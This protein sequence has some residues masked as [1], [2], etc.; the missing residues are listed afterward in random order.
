MCGF[1]AFFAPG[2]RFAPAL[3]DGVEQDLLHRGPDS[4]G[5]HDEEGWALVFRRL[6]IIDSR[7]VADQP[8]VDNETGSVLVFNGE[9]YNHAALRKEL[10]QLGHRFQTD[11]DTE[12]LLIGYRQW[13]R[14][15]LDRLEGM[16]AFVIVDRA[17]GLALAARDPFGIKP[18]YFVRTPECVAFASEMRP[19]QR[20][21]DAQADADTVLELLVFGFAGGTNSNLAGIERISGGTFLEVPLAGG[22]LRRGRFFDPL[23]ALE[24]RPSIAP[25][26]AVSRAHESIE[27]SVSDHL[28]SDVGYTIELS[29]GVDSSLVAA[30]AA[31]HSNKGLKSFGLK[32]PEGDPRDE[33]IWRKEVVDTY[34]LDHEEI[35]VDGRVYADAFERAV[36]HMEGPVPHGGCVLLMVLCERA[37]HSSKVILTGEG[38]DEFF[39]GYERYKDWRKLARQE[40]MSRLPFARL[41]PDRPPFRGVRRL[42]GRDAATASSIYVDPAQFETMAGRRLGDIEARTNASRRFPDLL[43]RIYAVDRMNYLDSLLLRQDKMS[44]AASVEA[45][46]PFVHRPLASVVDRIPREVMSPGGETKPVLKQVAEKYLSNALV[47]RRKIGLTIDYRGWLRDEKGLGRFL[48]GLDASDSALGSFLDRRQL[49]DAAAKARKGVMDGPDPFRLVNVEVWL[50]SLRSIPK[51]GQIFT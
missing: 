4:G 2:R 35:E 48:D 8:M 31:Q 27:R 9:I 7:T 19:L 47:R 37:R 29:G 40:T 10:E 30:I 14:A 3:L 12:A 45:R 28:M 24:E 5:R 39:G 44:M 22:D 26:D 20:L 38:A 42:V 6:S 25:A 1:A 33:S 46:V 43:R 17:K 15:I 18:L 49:K 13:G 50:R 34:G 11:S 23:A 32:L 16:F 21:T 51:R 36:R 41:L